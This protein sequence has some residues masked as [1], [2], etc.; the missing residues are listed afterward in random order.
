MHQNPFD[1]RA[2]LRPDGGAYNATP[3]VLARFS[4]EEEV[5]GGRKGEERGREMKEEVRGVRGT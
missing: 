5:K 3:N 4:G 1:G 2:P